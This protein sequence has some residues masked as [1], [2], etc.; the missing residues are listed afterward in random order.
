VVLIS[1][2]KRKYFP[3][4]SYQKLVTHLTKIEVCQED[5]MRA[6]KTYAEVA[7][8]KSLILKS[9][10]FA[11]GSRVEVIVFPAADSEDVFSTMDGIV[12]RKGIKPL[13][14]K[15]VEKIVHDARGVR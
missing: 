8:D 15:Q 10:P 4:P 1:V 13:T 11:P 7:S 12:K 6:V 14:M 9:L 3:Y 2:D 5:D